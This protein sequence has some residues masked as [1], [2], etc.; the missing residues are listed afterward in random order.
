MQPIEPGALIDGFRVGAL[1]HAGGTAQIYVASST[2]AD[3]PPFPLVMKVPP[4]G[5]GR[6]AIGIISFEMEFTILPELDGPHVPRFVAAGDLA[7]VPY[8]V[9]ERIEGEPLTDVIA[10]APLAPDEAARIGATLAD[11]VHSIHAQQV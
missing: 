6:P 2:A 11:A 4:L 8:L 7:A 10:R 5:P 1:L 3:P 9:M